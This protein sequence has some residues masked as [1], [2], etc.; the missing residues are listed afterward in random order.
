[1]LL[2]ARTQTGLLT[3][4][5]VGAASRCMHM[6]NPTCCVAV[7]G[8]ITREMMVYSTMAPAKA[9]VLTRVITMACLTLLKLHTTAST[10]SNTMHSNHDLSTDHTRCETIFGTCRLHN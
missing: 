8:N 2:G 6:T 7:R 9:T 3:A 1:M 4:V 5:A 10:I